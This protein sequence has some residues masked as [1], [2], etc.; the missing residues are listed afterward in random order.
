MHV[1]CGRNAAVPSLSFYLFPNLSIGEENVFFWDVVYLCWITRSP[2][3]DKDLCQKKKG[4]A[5]HLWSSSFPGRPPWTS[6]GEREQAGGR[7]WGERQFVANVEMF[8][9]SKNSRK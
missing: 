7:R 5:K 3:L 9:H 8:L 6:E 2:R 4:E 1:L